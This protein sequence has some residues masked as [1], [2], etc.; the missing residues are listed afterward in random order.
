MSHY[1]KN[2]CVC[3]S[4]CLADFP[5]YILVLI[6]KALYRAYRLFGVISVAVTAFD[7]LFEVSSFPMD[8]PKYWFRQVVIQN[9]SFA[10]R[11]REILFKYSFCTALN[12]TSRSN[13][14]FF[15]RSRVQISILGTDVV[16]SVARSRWKGVTAVA[17]CCQWMLQPTAW[18]TG[19]VI[20]RTLCNK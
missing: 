7:P 13:S 14:S 8:N 11:K 16:T 10:S 9:Y 4:V 19:G 15:W 3:L 5:G 12:W 17:D 1:E 6:L 2:C 18:A 20:E